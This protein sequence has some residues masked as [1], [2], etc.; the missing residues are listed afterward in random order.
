MPA[1]PLDELQAPRVERGEIDPL[2]SDEK[3]LL[4]YVADLTRMHAAVFVALSTGMRRGELPS[5]RWD[6]V[7]ELHASIYV[8][9]PRRRACAGE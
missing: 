6:S 1:N 4:L 7:D 2:N 9:A 3:A 8:P 5:L